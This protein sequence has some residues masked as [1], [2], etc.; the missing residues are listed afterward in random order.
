MGVSMLVRLY[1]FKKWMR[2][3]AVWVAGQVGALALVSYFLI[4]H[5]SR[6]KKSGMA[7]EI[8]DTWLR[9]SIFH[10]GTTSLAAFVPQ[11]TMRV[12]TYLFSH[13]LVGTLVLLAFLAGMALLLWRKAGRWNGTGPSQRQLA[14]LLRLPLVVNCVAAMAGQ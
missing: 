1:P 6:L 4:T 3:F 13:G 10:P 14:L 5:V 7:Q 11:Q 12:F 9:K 2:L 8:A